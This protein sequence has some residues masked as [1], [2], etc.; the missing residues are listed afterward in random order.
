[1]L[2]NFCPSLTLLFGFTMLK[3]NV[4]CTDII[5]AIIGFVAIILIILSM[6]YDRNQSRLFKKPQ[7]IK[8]NPLKYEERDHFTIVTSVILFSLPIAMALNNILARKLRK[9][10]QNTFACYF[11]PIIFISS[12][13]II[14]F[15]G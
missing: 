10:D 4:T 11:N 6:L 3:E 8:Q 1:M 13:V 14:W 2:I 5:Q 15:S 7:T 12:F 9:L